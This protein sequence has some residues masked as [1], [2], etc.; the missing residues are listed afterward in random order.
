MDQV[1]T[2]DQT[3]T[4]SILDVD[5]IPA[6]ITGS[7]GSAGS[8]TSAKSIQE[9]I[10]GVHGF[11][12][13]ETVTWSLNGGADASLFE[14]DSSSGTLSFKSAPDYENPTDS[15]S[16]NQYV[17][18]VR[19]TDALNN[20]SDQTHTV[21]I[22]DIGEKINASDKF[23]KLSYKKAE[24]NST[25]T[26]LFSPTFGTINGVLT[27]DRLSNA[28]TIT[29]KPSG[30]S[31]GQ[32]GI[33]FELLLGNSA[34]NNKG[35]TTTD[36][37]PL[38]DGLTTTGKNI[39]YFSYTET[40]DGSSPTATT[41]TYDPVKKQE[42]DFTDLR[43]DGKADTINLELIDGGYGDKDGIKNGTILDPSTAGVVDLTPEFKR[44][45]SGTALTVADALDT[46]SPAA[47]NLSVSISSNA[48]TVNQI[49]YVALNAN[50]SDVLTYDLIKNRGSILLSNVE[51]SDAPNLS[52]MNLTADISLINTQKLVFFE[53]VD[54]TLESLLAKNTNLDDFGSSFNILNLSDTTK[55][56]ANASNGGNT[57]A[58]SLQQGFS[59]VN[60]L[61]AS[62]LGFNPILDFSGFAGLSLKGTVSVFS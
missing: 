41:L 43:G 61:I 52:S 25:I 54:T 45:T 21:T 34:I 10:T 57:I 38:L 53:V 30:L 42:Q 51:N 19:A 59:G 32:T 44:S 55:D 56:S 24:D 39:A 5:E 29:D 12:A 2:F 14:I 36:L 27:L 18:V 49:G 23:Y 16:D 60:D 1:I 17:V 50:E 26:P 37:D 33:N 62:D 15:D 28:P 3:T 47:F 46:T 31:I 6:Q 58:I 8:A 11:T 4:I 13:N 22:T 7:S 20:T 40:G 48:S 9:N 35:K